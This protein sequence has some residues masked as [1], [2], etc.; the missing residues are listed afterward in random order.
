MGRW[1]W[2]WNG[3]W[4]EAAAGWGGLAVGCSGTLVFFSFAR[5]WSQT[6]SSLLAGE[7]KKKEGSFWFARPFVR[8]RGAKKGTLLFFLFRARSV[9][10]CVELWLHG[11]L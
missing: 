9:S 6:K 7:L 4:E 2:L 8:L 1:W 3:R 5:I 10:V 11:W